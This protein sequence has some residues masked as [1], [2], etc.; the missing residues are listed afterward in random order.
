MLKR[1]RI[2]WGQI[3]VFV[4]LILLSLGLAGALAMHSLR[5]FYVRSQVDNLAALSHLVGDEALPFF[6][7]GADLALA[8]RECQRLGAA[9]HARI[10]W[11]RPDGKVIGDSDKDPALMDNHAGRPEVRAALAGRIEPSQR[12]SDSVHETMLYV[13]FPLEREGRVLG[14]ARLARGLKGIETEVA[15]IRR[16]LTRSGLLAAALVIVFS[17]YLAHRLNRPLEELRQ[18]AERMAGGDFSRR[19][20]LDRPPQLVELAQSMNKMAYE[21]DTRI[22]EITRQR[23]EREA[24]LS[25]MREGVLAVDADERILMVNQACERMLGVVAAAAVGRLVQEV[26]RRPDLQQC[27]HE[28]LSGEAGPTHERVLEWSE[29]RRIHIASTPLRDEE[30][31]EN[32]VLIVLNDVTRLH[33]LENIRR[34][35]AANV[36]HELRTPIT[37]IKG[38]IE[39]LRDGAIDDPEN[40]GRFLEIIARQA[41]R[42]E[43]IIEDLLAL[44][45]IERDSENAGIQL[46]PLPLGPILEEVALH[47]RPLCEERGLTLELAA[48]PDLRARA[49]GRLL[50]QAVGN[51]VDNAIKYSREGRPIRIQA[52]AEGDQTRIDV[53]DMGCGIP[54]QHLPRIFE[55]FYRVDAARSR[56]LGGTGLG[57]AIVKHI[58]QTHGGRITVESRPDEGSIFTI[59]LPTLAS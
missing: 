24:I 27:I 21:L 29:G 55:R 30:G 56:D 59:W 15:S 11:I 52:R 26:L 39:T 35:F 44:S 3:A 20:Y 45:R 22:R 10:T 8:Q 4:L 17:L 50:G 42:L 41:N 28:A 40:A 57:L 34:Q 33:E 51:L 43:A 37:S 9:G 7:P 14:V 54:A 32:G 47:Y 23:N 46:Q 5:T 19:I 1:Q 53:I 12:P 18:T 13:A 36:S 6:A 25:S 31:A 49:N 16:L 58:V 2:E 48:D 38:F